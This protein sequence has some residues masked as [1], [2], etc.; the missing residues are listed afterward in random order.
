MH[1]ETLIRIFTNHHIGNGTPGTNIRN[2]CLGK[3]LVQI[4]Q[5]KLEHEAPDDRESEH[6][7]D[8]AV[9]V[10]VSVGRKVPDV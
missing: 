5:D 4:L 6:G 1:P 2:L 10:A 7:G 8:D 9:A 3:L